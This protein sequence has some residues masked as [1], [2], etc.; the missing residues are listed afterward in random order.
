MCTHTHTHTRH[1][2][3]HTYSYSSTPLI[4]S[5][6]IS[7]YFL[8]L[9]CV[10][11]LASSPPL[12]LHAALVLSVHFEGLSK[13]IEHAHRAGSVEQAVPYMEV[14]EQVCNRPAYAAGLGYCKGL[15]KW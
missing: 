14:A 11:F 9:P 13:L 7:A 12:S 5:I 3:T 15:L 4:H 1:L 8:L 10:P 2:A 6:L